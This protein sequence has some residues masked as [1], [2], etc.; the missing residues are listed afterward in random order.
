MDLGNTLKVNFAGVGTLI[1]VQATSTKEPN[2]ATASLFIALTMRDK[3][4]NRRR[5]MYYLR[6]VNVLFAVLMIIVIIPCFGHS[7]GMSW[8]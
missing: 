5:M 6:K 4:F 1:D 3:H 8:Q 7:M 2:Q